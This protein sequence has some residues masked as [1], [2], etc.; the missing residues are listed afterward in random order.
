MYTLCLR[1]AFIARHFLTTADSGSEGLPHSHAYTAELR[2][3]GG[4]LDGDGYLV[5]LR[6]VERFLDRAI[7]L[8]RDRLLN[9]LPAFTGLNPSLER[10]CRILA[11]EIVAQADMDEGSRMELRLWENENAWASWSG[12]S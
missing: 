3:R 9:D 4:E 5:D 2:I 6:M 7:D 8:F 10:F 11:A 12:G 1:R